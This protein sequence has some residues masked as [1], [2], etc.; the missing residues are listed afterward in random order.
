MRLRCSWQDPL[1]KALGLSA[2]AAGGRGGAAP[3]AGGAPVP[4]PPDPATLGFLRPE[5]SSDVPVIGPADGQGRRPIYF[6]TG[7][8]MMH[9]LN[10]ATGDD[11]DKP[12]MFHTG[13]GW[14]LNLVDDTI[15]MANTYAGASISAVALDDPQHKVMSTSGS[16]GAWGR[17][18]AVVDS[19]GTVWTTTG[20]GQ[21]N[22]ANNQYANSVVGVKVVNGELKMVDYYTPTNWDWLRKRDLDPNN[23]PTIFTFKGRELL[24]ASGKEC[25]MYLLDPKSLGGADPDVYRR[26]FLRCQPDSAAGAL[27]VGRSAERAGHWR[28]S[29][30][31]ALPV[32]AP[33]T[34]T[35]VTKEGGVAAQVADAAGK[36]RRFTWVSRDD[37][38][39]PS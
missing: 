25:R 12:F 8:G 33:I 27:D 20:D 7:D 1:A 11:L 17:R 21:Y 10:A 34:N 24:A 28:R 19:S 18:G 5:G 4:P 32:Q 9:T 26:C 38:A 13:K 36:S 23:T 30:A 39:G 29:G 16:G 35:P 31:A 3:A 14:G 37:G 2:P 22:P 15:Y 6:V